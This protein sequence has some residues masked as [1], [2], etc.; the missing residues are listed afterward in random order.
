MDYVFKT[1]KVKTK[2]ELK[3]FLNFLQIRGEKEFWVIDLW[4]LQI[5][6]INKKKKD[7][8]EPTDL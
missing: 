5:H 2:N 4:F 1:G 3:Y 8:D 7:L 6:L